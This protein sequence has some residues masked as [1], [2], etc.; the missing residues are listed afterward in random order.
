MKKNNVLN[1]DKMWFQ[2]IKGLV[3][4]EDIPMDKLIKVL[5]DEV[6]RIIQK[7]LDPEAEIVFELD[8]E[9]EEVR[10][11]NLK[12]PVVSDEYY[13]ELVSLDPTNSLIY[14]SES[15][16]KNIDPENCQD[17]DE[18][19]VKIDLLNLKEGKKENKNN[20]LVAIKSSIQ[21]AIK[22]LKK[23]EIFDKFSHRI[24]EN[25]KVVFTTRNTNGS[26]NVQ[27]LEDGT[28]AYLPVSLIST[29]RNINPG[30]ILP[31]VIESVEN[32][33][34]LNQIVVSLDSPNIISEILRNSIPE[35]H[36]GL[37]SI[38]AMERIP[39]ERTKVVFESK[40]GLSYDEIYGAIMGKESSRIQTIIAEMNKDLSNPKDFEKLDIIINTDNL[41]EKITRAMAPA[42]V[43]D[44]VQKD[45]KSYYVI[46]SKDNLPLA[47]G[48]KG[49]N[50]L[51]ASKISGVYLDVIT[52]DKADELKLQYNKTNLNLTKTPVKKYSRPQAEKSSVH[53]TK[54]TSRAVSNIPMSLDGFDE[55]IRTYQ[56]QEHDLFSTNEFENLDFDEL[57]K[58]HIEN[59]EWS[60][61]DDEEQETI[62]EDTESSTSDEKLNVKEYQQ[63][64]ET[65]KN[66]K[67]DNDLKSFGLDG[68]ID[69]GEFQDEDDWEV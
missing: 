61:N 42:S 21:Q 39:G 55:D 33:A 10:V 26:W 34:K 48:K 28:P 12:A 23:Q 45:A 4:K 14:V 54:R 15:E 29:K 31:V 13:E 3:E 57:L 19:K 44:I 43:I 36:D 46:V 40:A 64:K 32:D 65:L 67:V 62:I 7:H 11:Y 6:T 5:Q 60:S 16:A 53:T 66:F 58:K 56:E 18:V 20:V 52:T 22:Q 63:A 51:L 68:E 8:E 41:I 50:S 37:I 47:I 38:S 49:T 35:I 27:I 1:S 2:I 30:T 17:G 69:F 24:G 9:K 25:I 59:D